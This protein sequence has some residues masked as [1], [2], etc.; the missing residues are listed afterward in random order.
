MNIF[1]KKK[2]FYLLVLVISI[3][4]IFFALYVE[5]ILQYKACKLCLY[6]RIPYLIAIFISFIG[7]N[8]YKNDKILLIII[9][10][11]ALSFLISG[12][13]Y[14]IEKNIFVEFSGCATNN[15]DI[16][17]KTTL[18]KTLSDNI[19]SSCKDV[20][21]RLFGISLAGINSILSLLIVI[22][23]LRTLIYEKN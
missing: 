8:Y 1:L 15:L 2:N 19:P 9:L 5:Y 16:T 23:S 21:F 11:F 20:N 6:Q 10:I 7:L 4:T 22:Y 13:H 17:D 14:G 18:L 3:L 12:Y